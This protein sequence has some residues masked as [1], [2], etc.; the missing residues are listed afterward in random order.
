MPVMEGKCALFKT[1]AD[2]DAFPLCIR[3]KDVDEI[4][5][6]DYWFYLEGCDDDC[7]D[8]VQSRD[9]I[10]LSLGFAGERATGG[11]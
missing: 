2:V 3:S 5:K 11:E 4:V 10:T 1:F 7:S 6:V 9:V 8:P